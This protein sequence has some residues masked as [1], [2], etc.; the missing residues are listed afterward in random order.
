VDARRRQ[1]ESQAIG[2]YAASGAL[3]VGSVVTLMLT[4]SS[5]SKA[6]VALDGAPGSMMLRLRTTL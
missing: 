6:S 3:L 2:F 5:P 1:A 4:P